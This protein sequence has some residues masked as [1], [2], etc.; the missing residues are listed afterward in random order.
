[1]KIHE[2]LELV[3]ASKQSVGE[4]FYDV[5]FTHHPDV[6]EHFHNVNMKRQAVLLTT[7]LMLVERY[8][9]RP[10]LTIET[11]LQYL[12]TQHHDRGIPQELYPKWI[13]A[14]LETLERF[15]GGDWTHELA[16]EW[17]EAFGQSIELMFEGYEQHYTV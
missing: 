16:M 2:S 8:Y 7:A 5:F 9:S 3:L 14:M 17:K 1:M 6:Q 15:H 10:N 13:D 11:Y 12:G 4:L